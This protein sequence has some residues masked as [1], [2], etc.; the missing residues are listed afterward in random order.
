MGEPRR[1]PER[2][3]AG[4]GRWSRQG[5]RTRAD[6][7][8]G[9]EVGGRSRLPAGIGRQAGCSCRESVAE[10]GE[11]HLSRSPFERGV[12]R[13]RQAER[14]SG[15]SYQPLTRREQLGAGERVRGSAARVITNATLP[16]WRTRSQDPG[17]QDDPMEGVLARLLYVALTPRRTQRAWHGVSPSMA[18][19]RRRAEGALTEVSS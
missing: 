13:G 14:W 6:W 15:S 1:K 19:A 9:R 2:A 12:T 10:V 7:P 11:T 5:G 3:Q 8:Q 18:F 16:A 17:R 4:P